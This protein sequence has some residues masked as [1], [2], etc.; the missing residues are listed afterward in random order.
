MNY[1]IIYVTDGFSHTKVCQLF[2][3]LY[4]L[5]V[6]KN[7]QKVQSF[8]SLCFNIQVTSVYM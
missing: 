5:A 8:S 4:Q 7:I 6:I 3:V 2:V 1:D